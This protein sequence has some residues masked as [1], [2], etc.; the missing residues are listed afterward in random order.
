MDTGE[1]AWSAVHESL[2]ARWRVASPPSIADPLRKIWSVTA[3]G[4]HPGRNGTSPSV[5]GTG[6]D[7]IAALRD[8][9]DQLRGVD[10]STGTRLEEVRQPTCLD[11]QPALSRA[12]L[13]AYRPCVR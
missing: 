9:D 1:A 5:T 13:L 11:S 3:I 7:E 12:L 6:P 10:H 8:L 2:P 4:P